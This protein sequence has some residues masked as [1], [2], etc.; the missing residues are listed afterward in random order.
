MKLPMPFGDKTE[1]KPK[2]RSNTRSK[3]RVLCILEEGEVK[4]MQ[5]ARSHDYR[6]WVDE[7]MKKYN[8]NSSRFEVDP[9]TRELY[10]PG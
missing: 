8:L 10:Y 5:Y 3:R 6:S 7:I 1:A 9:N 2:P 4:G